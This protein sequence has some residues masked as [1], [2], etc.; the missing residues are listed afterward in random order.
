MASV[1]EVTREQERPLAF[2]SG[3]RLGFDFWRL[4]IHVFLLIGA[5]GLLP[6]A[7]RNQKDGVPFEYLGIQAILLGWITFVTIRSIRRNRR[8]YHLFVK[9]QGGIDS[10]GIEKNRFFTGKEQSSRLNGGIRSEVIQVVGMP[11]LIWQIYRFEMRISGAINLNNWTIAAM[12]GFACVW[13][14]SIIQLVT[15]FYRGSTKEEVVVLDQGLFFSNQGPKWFETFPNEFLPWS[16][17]RRVVASGHE[18]SWDKT[19]DVEGDRWPWYRTIQFA[20]IRDEDWERM[21][22]VI[23]ERVAVVR[24]GNG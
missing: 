22:G 14:L 16:N 24:E 13:L 4:P 12:I 11:I 20:G 9:C 6:L 2:M 5:I 15:S 1:A 21:L 10:S 17:I 7:H 23:G 19:L 3:G 8:D 18:R